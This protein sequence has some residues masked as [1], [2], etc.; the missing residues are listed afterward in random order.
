[1]TWNQKS[2]KLEGKAGFSVLIQTIYDSKIALKGRLVK[3]FLLLVL[4]KV[5]IKSNEIE[6]WRTCELF[7]YT[8]LFAAASTRFYD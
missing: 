7:I 2:A 1:M 3:L 8:S 5:K 4:G 6:N